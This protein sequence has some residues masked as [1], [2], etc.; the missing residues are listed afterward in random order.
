MTENSENSNDMTEP[1]LMVRELSAGYG[2][3]TVVNEVTIAIPK[4]KI[5]GVVGHNGAGKTTLLRAVCGLLS[6][7]KGDIKYKAQEITHMRVEQRFR[8]GIVFIPSEKFVFN[9]LSIVDNLLMGLVYEK[10]RSVRSARIEEVFSNF[11]MLKQKSDKLAGTLSGG[12]KR[13]LSMGIALMSNPNLL[14]LDEPSLGLAPVVVDELFANLSKICET[15]NMSV[16]VVEQN[17]PEMLNIIDGCYVVRAG[18]IVLY[19]TVEQMR[20]RKSFWEL[21]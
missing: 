14:L 13:M 1:L 15:R 5:I 18:R 21:F 2:N 10:N 11:P 7:W 17:I 8:L 3:R 19:E 20:N 4:D 16:L 12:Q 9:E 6:A